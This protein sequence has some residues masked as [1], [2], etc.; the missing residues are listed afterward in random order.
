MAKRVLLVDDAAVF[1][2]AARE[3][4]EARGYEVVGEAD[5]VRDAIETGRRLQ[6]DAALVDLRLPDGSGL[7]VAAALTAERPDLTVVLITADSSAP[8]SE[9]LGASGARG[10]VRKS[11]LA[12]TDFTQ[13]WPGS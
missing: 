8:S 10:F 5:S 2:Q 4:L 11:E 12:A 3:V 6:P 9:E 13:F 1:R 7:D